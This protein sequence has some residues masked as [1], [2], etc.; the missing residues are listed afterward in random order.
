ME[1]FTFNWDLSPKRA[2]LIR[3]KVRRWQVTLRTQNYNDTSGEAVIGKDSFAEMR[4]H[5]RFVLW[6]IQKS[7]TG[8]KTFVLNAL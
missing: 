4:L 8:F 2:L 1:T 5:K 7:P 6:T 3:Q